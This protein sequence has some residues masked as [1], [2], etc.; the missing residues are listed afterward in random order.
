[1]AKWLIQFGL[2]LFLLFFG[3][4][5][6]MQ[7]AHNGM[8]RMRGYADPAFPSVVEMKRND[9]GEVEAAVFGETVTAAD[10]Q[11]KQETMRELTSFNVFSELGR[12]LADAAT[13]LMNTLLSLIGRVLE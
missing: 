7:Q 2:M 9:S 11:K 6:G 10:W 5:F 12:R 13:A 4:L 8:E 3:V 1:M